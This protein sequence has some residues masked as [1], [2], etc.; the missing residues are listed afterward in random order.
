MEARTFYL[1]AIIMAMSSG[2]HAHAE[3]CSDAPTDSRRCCKMPSESTISVKLNAT[4]FTTNAILQTQY[5]RQ[6][7]RTLDEWNRSGADLTLKYAGRS[8]VL[9][10]Q[11]AYVNIYMQAFQPYE[12]PPSARVMCKANGYC[13]DAA[14]PGPYECLDNFSGCIDPTQAGGACPNWCDSPGVRFNPNV[15]F[16]PGYPIDG[17]VDFRG[18]L[19][20][21]LGHA[22]GHTHRYET[23]CSV[24]GDQ[25]WP[26]MPGYN[27]GRGR[28]LS[29]LDVVQNV[30]DPTYGYN[31]Y[32][33]STPI[34]RRSKSLTSFPSS[35]A[36][37]SGA[38]TNLRPA[39]AF[40]DGTASNPSATYCLAYAASDAPYGTAHQILSTRGGGTAWEWGQPNGTSKGY[41]WGVTR[42]GV[43]GAAS[44]DNFMLAWVDDSS[45]GDELR[46]LTA[47]SSDCSSW[48]FPVEVV[49]SAYTRIAPAL[50]FDWYRNRYVLIWLEANGGTLRAATRHPTTGSWSS[51]QD[52][53]FQSSLS[54]SIS[55]SYG[56][57]GVLSFTLPDGY[58]QFC[59]SQISLGA[60]GTLTTTYGTCHSSSIFA[61]KGL[62]GTYGYDSS[63]ANWQ[64][65]LSFQRH[66]SI[67]GSTLRNVALRKTSPS[68][69]YQFAESGT[70][71]SGTSRPRTDGAIVYSYDAIHAPA[72][73][74][75]MSTYAW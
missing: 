3:N 71:I 65:V 47:T 70:V 38:K 62:S 40:A 20:H 14:I 53:G 2:K 18:F 58:G 36:A 48:Q 46:I 66:D 60:T 30:N 61:R 56:N 7:V 27:L 17:E 37:P 11:S 22:L 54:P 43:V 69:S 1:A 52:L 21:E 16:V 68:P 35:T 5:E 4:S 45:P 9:G 72:A 67:T 63:L 74:E 31:E 13:N 55:Y 33:G 12:F 50:A 51:A 23:N 41:V 10:V 42:V 64:Y 57:T 44:E 34:S 26:M 29:R 32:A 24:L 6:V 49:S 39:L 28:Y 59:S 25:D 15:Q 75:F 8:T 73:N 19:M